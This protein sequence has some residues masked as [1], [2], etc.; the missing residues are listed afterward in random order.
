[1]S[2]PSVPLCVYCGMNS[3]E[4]GCQDAIDKYYDDAAI[5]AEHESSKDDDSC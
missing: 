1:M 2:K 3:T 5:E 4:C